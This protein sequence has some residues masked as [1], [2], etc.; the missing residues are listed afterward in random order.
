MDF[1]DYA[2][3]LLFL[4]LVVLALF[5]TGNACRAATVWMCYRF[6][7]GENHRL[8][9]LLLKHYLRHPYGWFLHHNSADLAKNVIDEVGNVVV[10][11]IQRVCMFMVRGFLATLICI[12]LLLIDPLVAVTTALCLLMVYSIFYRFFQK[13]LTRIGRMRFDANR[14]RYKT[15]L[16]AVSSIKEAKAP[17]HRDHFLKAYGR[18]SKQ[19]NDLMIS[20]E[21]IGDLPGYLTEGLTVGGMLAVMVYFLAAKGGANTAIPLIALYIVAA[22]RLAPALQD[23]YR[24][25]VKIKFYLPALER[26]HEELQESDSM[27]HGTHDVERLGLRTGDQP[28]RHLLFLPRVGCLLFSGI[29]IS[30]SRATPRRPWWEKAAQAKQPWRT[31]SPVFLNL[32]KEP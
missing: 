3:F 18:H 13:R 1:R 30:R 27:D 6:S 32:A 19:T 25:L 17:Y 8:S 16:E 31:L 7:W 20:G 14:L 2:S 15:V 5:L 21:M 24:D 9:E 10:N 4:G 22:I 28:R 11:V 29:S 26:I 23:M 12:G